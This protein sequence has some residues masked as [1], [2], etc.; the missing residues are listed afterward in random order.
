[1][2]GR[3]NQEQGL[4]YPV[5]ENGGGQEAAEAENGPRKDAEWMPPRARRSRRLAQTDGAQKAVI[6]LGH[7]LAAE[8]MAAFRALGGGFARGMIEAMLLGQGRHGRVE[9]VNQGVSVF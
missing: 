3:R 1:V 4:G 7:A 9:S 2:P 5:K 8:E 6:V